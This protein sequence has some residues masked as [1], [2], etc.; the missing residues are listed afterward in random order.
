[1]GRSVSIPSAARAVVF[2]FLEVE[3]DAAVDDA[4]LAFEDELTVLREKAIRTWPS[5]VACRTF[6]GIE[7]LAIAQNVYAQFGVSEYCGLMSIWLLPR[8]A[9]EDKR[10]HEVD[11]WIQ[12][13]NAWLDQAEALLLAFF[14][15]HIRCPGSPY[16]LQALP[17]VAA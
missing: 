10:S 6:V 1:M 8:S 11:A 5:M 12:L 13:R 2:Q 3:E 14:G 17:K 7:D 15:T 9:P 16:Q 4:H